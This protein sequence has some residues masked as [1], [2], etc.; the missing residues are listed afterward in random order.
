MPGVDGIDVTRC[1]RRDGYR[2]PIVLFSGR[3]NPSV[4]AAAKDAGATAILPKPVPESMLLD[5]LTL[6]VA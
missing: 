1:I 4:C 6:G 5:I 3:L 2:G